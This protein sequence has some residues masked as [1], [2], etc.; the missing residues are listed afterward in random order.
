MRSRSIRSFASSSSSSGNDSNSGNDSGSNGLSP[1]Y[2]EKMKHPLHKR[3][4]GR[5]A[6]QCIGLEIDGINK[7]TFHF[8]IVYDFT[9]SHPNAIPLGTLTIDLC[10]YCLWL[11]EMHSILQV[12]SL[13]FGNNIA[14]VV[15]VNSNLEKRIIAPYCYYH[16]FSG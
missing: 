11:A 7:H 10:E 1:V 3:A 16:T 4:L 15:S 14:N 6:V 9:L 13:N 12:L 2:V 8:L 5:R